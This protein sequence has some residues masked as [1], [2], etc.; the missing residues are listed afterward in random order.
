MAFPQFDLLIPGTRK[1]AGAYTNGAWVPTAPGNI[2]IRGS[3]QPASENELRLLPEGRREDGAYAI[4]SRSEIRTGD[5]FTIGGQAHEV[6]RAQVWQNGVIP[7][8]LGI[9]VRVQP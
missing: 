1:G 7:H 5:V 9:A 6:L 2:S 8:Y 3:V 4:R